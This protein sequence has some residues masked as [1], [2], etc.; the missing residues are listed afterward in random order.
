VTVGL[1]NP[2]SPKDEIM[3]TSVIAAQIA[4]LRR[5][6]NEPL[7]TNYSDV[8]MTTYIETYPLVDENGE[9]PRVPSTTTPDLMMVNPDWIATYD[10]HA[11]A[12]DIWDEKAAV[13]SV[14]YDFSADGASLN[15]S[16]VYQ[17]C[18]AQARYH[19][20]RR[21]PKTI[22]QVPDLSHERTYETNQS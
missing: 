21:S 20:S 19:R 10:L 7:N 3:T 17:Q 16:Q 8:D 14:D 11:A 9:S 6:V 22:T 18:M 5:M 12:A 13:V 1:T 15:R 2:P 4:Q